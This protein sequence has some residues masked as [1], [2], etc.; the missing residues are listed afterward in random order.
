MDL[1]YWGKRLSSSSP[2]ETARVACEKLMIDQAGKI[3]VNDEA[4]QAC[5]DEFLESLSVSRLN[6]L[7]KVYGCKTFRAIFWFIRN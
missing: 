5:Y 2:E 7:G 6:V 3:N 4:Y 1:L